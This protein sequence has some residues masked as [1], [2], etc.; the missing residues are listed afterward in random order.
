MPTSAPREAPASHPPSATIL[1]PF[2]GS[3]RVALDALHYEEE[4]RLRAWLDSS[5]LAELVDRALRLA[6][7]RPAA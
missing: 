3:P 7:E 5:G 2:E 1:L 6:E 4:L